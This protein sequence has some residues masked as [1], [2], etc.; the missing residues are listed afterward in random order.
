[1]HRCREELLNNKWTH[2]NEEIPLGEVLSTISL[3]REI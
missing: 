1:M 2:I 3:K